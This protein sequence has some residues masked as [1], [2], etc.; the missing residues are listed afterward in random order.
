MIMVVIIY[1]VKFL[2]LSLSRFLSLIKY[3]FYWIIVLLG[4]IFKMDRGKLFCFL[5]TFISYSPKVLSRRFELLFNP[6]KTHCTVVS[7]CDFIHLSFRK[8]LY[9]TWNSFFNLLEIL[10]SVI[11]IYPI[12]SDDKKDHRGSLVLVSSSEGFFM[13]LRWRADIFLNLVVLFLSLNV[14][15]IETFCS[16]HIVIFL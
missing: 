11:L 4:Q 8:R 1:I 9:F 3:N 10:I 7:N 12:L 13:N 16:K 14:V 15:Y 6:D 5:L 2:A